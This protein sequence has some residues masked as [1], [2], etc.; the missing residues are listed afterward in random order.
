MTEESASGSNLSDASTTPRRVL[1]MPEAFAATDKEDWVSWLKYFGN[2]AKLNKWSDEEKRDFLAVRLRGAAQ[3]TYLSLSDEIQGERFEVLAEALGKK[4]APAERLELYK[5]EF[6]ARRRMPGEKLGELAASL[7]KMARKAFPGAPSEILDRLAMDRFIA[8]LDNADLRIRVRES[9]PKTLDESLSR[10][11]QLEAIYEAENGLSRSKTSR[12][13]TVEKSGELRI[14]EML[15]KQTAALE[16]AVNWLSEHA[17]TGGN[18]DHRKSGSKFRGNKK[19]CWKCG[20]VG[21]FKAKCPTQDESSQ[22]QGN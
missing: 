17:K 5:A 15:N 19:T 1:V 10:A 13:Q 3:E 18:N 16:K 21:H 20:G 7:G 9:N 22:K 6:Q 11:I 8:S 2:C 14:A 4:F 12:V